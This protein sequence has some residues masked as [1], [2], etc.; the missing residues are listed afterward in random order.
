MEQTNIETAQK[1]L[2]EETTCPLDLFVSAVK[3]EI[4]NDLQGQSSISLSL[5]T[6]YKKP[7]P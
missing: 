5:A 4:M 3:K 1:V 6:T 2:A 7:L